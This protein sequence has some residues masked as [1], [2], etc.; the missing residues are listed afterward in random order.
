MGQYTAS[1]RTIIKQLT[2]DKNW[3]LL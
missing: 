1:V 3:T 2:W